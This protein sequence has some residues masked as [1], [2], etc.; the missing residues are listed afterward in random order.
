MEGEAIAEYTVKNHFA[1]SYNR[2]PGKFCA[3]GC[4]SIAEKNTRDANEWHHIF[5]GGCNIPADATDWFTKPSSCQRSSN[6]LVRCPKVIL[7]SRSMG[8]YSGEMMGN[9]SG[10]EGTS[11]DSSRSPVA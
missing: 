5:E 1:S 9:R 6:P 7:R 4:Q 8:D 11:G 2:L 3:T 10:G